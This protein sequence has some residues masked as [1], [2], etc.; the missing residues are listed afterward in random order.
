MR[1]NDERREIDVGFGRG[2]DDV[3]AR[4]PRLEEEAPEEEEEKIEGNDEGRG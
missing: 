2:A 4:I 1:V 3:A